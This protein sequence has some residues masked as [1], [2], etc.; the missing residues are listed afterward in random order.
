MEG[1]D[2]GGSQESAMQLTWLQD[3]ARSAAGR[4]IQVWQ[5]EDYWPKSQLFYTGCSKIT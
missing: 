4:E 3:N 5:P 1:G 2:G